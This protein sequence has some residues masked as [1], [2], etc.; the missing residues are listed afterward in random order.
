MKMKFI[1]NLGL[2]IFIPFTLRTE[3]IVKSTPVEAVIYENKAIIKRSV[4]INLKKGINTFI[5]KDIPVNLLENTIIVYNPVKNS[6][7]FIKEYEIKHEIIKSE[8]NAQ[9]K[10]LKN[11]LKELKNRLKR[12]K[13]EKMV[14]ELNINFYKNLYEKYPSVIPQDKNSDKENFVRKIDINNLE[15]F[16]NFLHKGIQENYIK[17]RELEEKIKNTKEDIKVIESQIDYFQR[18]ETKAIKVL[19]IKIESQKDTTGI[20]YIKYVTPAAFWYPVYEFLY[21]GKSDIIKGKFYAVVSQ[22]TGED[23]NNIKLIIAT[24]SPL[25]DITLPEPIPWIVKEKSERYLLS[26]GGLKLA[27]REVETKETGKI[28]KSEIGI[29]IKLNNK[30]NI[31]SGFQKK[32]KVFVKLLNIKREDSYYTAVPSINNYAYLT[33]KISNID[34]IPIFPGEAM[35]YVDGNYT[36]KMKIKKIISPKENINLSFGIDEEIKLEKK[37]LHRKKGTSGIFGNNNE[38][39]FG[40]KIKVANYKKKNINLIIKEPLPFSENEK[41]KIELYDSNYEVKKVEERGIH[42]WELNLKPLEKKELIYRFR[43]IYP[44]DMK[45]EGL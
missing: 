16:L 5:I 43:V 15:A 39:D 25:F 12:Y 29:Q 18:E 30:F 2:L 37:L 31:P 13:D 10:K 35:L 27:K 38:I 7:F 19:N 3:N 36:G 14:I 33:V 34:K 6:P 23:W 40:Y 44:K 11:K 8:E 22:Y 17:L 45:I 24:G 21:T 42:I 20:I 41:I 32:K 9:L 26:K 4:K 28:Q 1:V